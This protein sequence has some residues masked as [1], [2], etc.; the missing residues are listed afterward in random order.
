EVL[1]RLSRRLAPLARYHQYEVRGLENIPAKGRCIVAF[2]H[3]LATYDIALFAREALARRERPLRM[4]VDH[5][6]FKIPG[7]NRIPKAIGLV[8]GKPQ[9]ARALLAE[10]ELVGVAPGG[11]RE[12]LKPSSQAYEIMWDR[13]RGFARLALETQTPIVLAACPAADDLYRV[14]DNPITRA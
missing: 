4:L 2:N 3:S 5:L 12:A 7:I 11:M 14:I 1:E 10:D 6:F 8:D 13:Q 9:L